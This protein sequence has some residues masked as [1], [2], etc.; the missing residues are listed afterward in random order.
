[1]VLSIKGIIITR[2]WGPI[3][4]HSVLKVEKECNKHKML[5]RN[6]KKVFYVFRETSFEENEEKKTHW[7]KGLRKK[8]MCVF[9]SS[10]SAKLLSKNIKHFF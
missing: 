5:G 9:L 4:S 6:T 3:P 7:L 10:F 2:P 1:M 8:P